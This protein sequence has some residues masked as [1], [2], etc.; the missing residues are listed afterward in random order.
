MMKKNQ[1]SRAQKI[2][3]A[4]G[5]AIIRRL[6]K[7]YPHAGMML[8]FSSHW[9][10]LVAVIL[11]AQCTDKKVNQVTE[12]LFQKYRTLEDYIA[13]D[14]REFER[15]IHATGF[16]RSKTKHILTTAKLI[17][18]KYNGKIPRTMEEMLTLRGVAR[19]TANV[20]LGNAHNIVDGIAVDT[21]VRR[22]SQRL[23]LT[24]KNDP[25]KIEQD[26]MKILPKNEWFKT[27]YLLIEHGRSICTAKDPRCDLCP[28]RDICPSA[29]QFPRFK[30]D[31]ARQKNCT[32]PQGK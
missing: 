31:D 13:A 19:K 14:P 20:V 8:N 24:T 23:G 4:R 16:F 3:T 21:H 30:K 26:L 28:L 2:V 7:T 32:T 5:R 1:F 22:L 17:K 15:D 25:N 10:L 29:F 6:K 27:T 18:E 9:E 12:K 11:S